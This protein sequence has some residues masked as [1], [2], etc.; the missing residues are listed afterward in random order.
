MDTIWNV[1]YGVDVDIQN[2]MN[3]PYFDN[4][5]WVFVQTFQKKPIFLLASILNK[6]YVLFTK[7]QNHY[8]V[9]RIFS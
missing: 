1:A 5:E 3:N 2:D 6:Y 8:L 9:L 4:S 7:S